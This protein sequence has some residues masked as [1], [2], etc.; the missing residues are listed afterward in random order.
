MYLRIRVLRT[1][2]IANLFVFGNINTC[3]S[4]WQ[5]KSSSLLIWGLKVRWLNKEMIIQC[6]FFQRGRLCNCLICSWFSK[7]WKII[8]DYSFSERW[9][10]LMM[11]SKLLC[12]ALLGSL[13]L[14]VRAEEDEVEGEN[15]EEWEDNSVYKCVI[16][17]CSGWR[18]NKVKL[19]K[20]ENRN[21]SHEICFSSPTWRTSFTGTLSQST[22]GPHLR[23]F[24]APPL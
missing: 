18:L 2:F 13:L 12:L 23:R 20:S 8:L 16:E 22:R 3:T 24:Q 19:I 11:K 5:G 10:E 9:L 7:R 17:S 15:G 21:R 1:K 4:L 14:V 6:R